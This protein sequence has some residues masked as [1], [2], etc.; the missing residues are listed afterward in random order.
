MSELEVESRLLWG[1]G[2]TAPTRSDVVVPHNNADAVAAVDLAGSRGL[3]ARGLGRGYGDCAQNAGGLVLDGVGL[4]GLIDMDLSTGI[5]TARAGTSL[6]DLMAWLVPLGY[7]VPVTPGTRMVTLGGAI[8]ADIH[9]KNHHS[10]GS[11]C[12]HV[13][14][15]RLLDGRGEIR[16]ISVLSDPETFWATAGG[17][18]L[19]GAIL[20]ATIQMKP[21]ESSLL[22]VDTDRAPDLET[23]M[24]LMI[25]GDDNY[26]YSVAW[27]DLMKVGK[28][29]GRSVLERGSFAS[30]DRVQAEGIA[31]PLEYKTSQLPA[32]PDLVPSGLLNSLSIRAFN[33]LWYRKAPSRKRDQLQTIQGFFHPLDMISDWNRI[34][35]KRGFLQWQFSVPDAATEVVHDVVER[36][37][38]S[39]AS[40]FLAVLKRFGKGN[41]GLLS[42]PSKG[43]TLALDMPVGPGIDRLLDELDEIV[44]AAGG[45]IYLIKDSRVRA[46]HMEKMYP[47]VDE[48][49]DIKEKLD[50]DGVFKSD[51][52]RRLGLC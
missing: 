24:Q 25:S 26:D 27:I 43:W 36:L 34:Y 11:F 29:M 32:P 21:I 3:L 45:R 12:D 14:S 31:N 22:S 51:L 46:E 50:P 40:S 42:F 37:A 18:G 5:V 35:G 6:D 30:L 33:E 48:W 7:F 13:R 39:D 4:N 19:T 38:S 17:L 16:D 2:R 52:G 28:G 15:F 8:A 49:L 44:L 20:D 47:R 1:W 23:L 10:A 41:D 9:G